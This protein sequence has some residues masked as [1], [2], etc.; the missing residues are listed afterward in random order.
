MTERI[1]IKYKSIKE[2]HENYLL[3]YSP[4]T[5]YTKMALIE[6]SIRKD[7]SQ[8]EIADL[9]EKESKKWT[10]KYPLTTMTSAFHETGDLI[11]LTEIKE[12]SSFV[13][14][15]DIHGKLLKSTW[16]IKSSP[17]ET[18]Y[19]D[20]DPGAYFT[21]QKIIKR[22]D[23]EVEIKKHKNQMRALKFTAIAW[24]AV[25][26]ATYEI[27][28]YAGPK[29]ISLLACIY[30]LYK[31][32]RSALKAWGILPQSKA[33]FKKQEIQRKKD[34]YYYH[35]ELNP[36]GFLKLKGENFE[37]EAKAKFQEEINSVL[38]EEQ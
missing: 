28:N 31:A 5:K 21:Q 1:E 4:P 6:L 23:P 18:F 17:D 30:G 13:C 33:E 20:D 38:N 32:L 25:I 34:H 7:L 22:F 27:S 14:H 16:E 12:S 29:W 26:P 3:E 11:D 24:G 15:F 19:P 37:L 9:I 10:A 36:D 35:C 8:K 2:L